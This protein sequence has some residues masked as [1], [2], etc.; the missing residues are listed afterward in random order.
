MLFFLLLTVPVGPVLCVLCVLRGIHSSS[1][2]HSPPA[3]VL[4][5]ALLTVRLRYQIQRE[6]QRLPVASNGERLIHK[7]E[8][9]EMDDSP[10][11]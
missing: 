8:S 11:T 7:V 5:R 4:G 9:F 10:E 2:R 1:L 6:V 3:G